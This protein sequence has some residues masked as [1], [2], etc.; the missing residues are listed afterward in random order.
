MIEIEN[1]VEQLRA[2][3]LTNGSSLG[4]HSGLLEEAADALEKLQAENVK[5]RDS[6]YRW[7]RC[8]KYCPNCGAKMDAKQEEKQCD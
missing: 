3:G 2:R 5:L 7:K 1:L 6:R 8:A 4:W